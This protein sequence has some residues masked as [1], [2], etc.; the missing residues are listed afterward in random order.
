[1]QTSLVRSVVLVVAAGGAAACGPFDNDRLAAEAQGLNCGTAEYEPFHAGSAR[2]EGG[3]VAVAAQIAE[4]V[5]EALAEPSR[6]PELFEEIDALYRGSSGLRAAVRGASDAAYG[7]AADTTLGEALDL[8]IV[9]AIARGET[10]TKS[11]QL[12]PLGATIS[13]T[14]VRFF[15]LA[16]A[17]RAREGTWAGYDGAMTYLGTGPHGA[18]AEAQAIAEVLVARGGEVSGLFNAGLAGACALDRALLAANASSVPWNA[19]AALDGAIDGLDEAL[20][21]TLAEALV[22]GLASLETLG[23]VEAATEVLADAE[24]YAAIEPALLRKGVAEADLAELRDDFAAAKNALEIGGDPARVVDAE[25]VI[26]L[27]SAAFGFT[28]P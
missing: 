11:S 7:D 18:P 8:S 9:S 23:E 12:G 4:E 16:A 24:L 14:L 1:M 5:A 22:R 6:G 27:V 26:A 10:S 21:R 3:H 20:A 28:A 15:T 19:D 13:T 17:A 25:R 2:A